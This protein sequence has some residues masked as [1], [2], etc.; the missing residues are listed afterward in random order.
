MTTFTSVENNTIALKQN[1]SISDKIV[2]IGKMFGS[3]VNKESEWLTA[4]HNG[5]DLVL[6]NVECTGSVVVKDELLDDGRVLPVSLHDQD[7]Q[8]ELSLGLL[9]GDG[10]VSLAG[11]TADIW[12]NSAL[13]TDSGVIEVI[14]WDKAAQASPVYKS[15]HSLIWSS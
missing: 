1:S 9:T 2:C 14:T 10:A 13:I 3:W 4:R 7:H 6:A 12:H 15:L 11:L 5:E 8:S